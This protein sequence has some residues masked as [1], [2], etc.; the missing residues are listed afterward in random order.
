MQQS[1]RAAVADSGSGNA[2]AHKAKRIFIPLPF[3]MS[4][5]YVYVCV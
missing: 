2:S 5:Y 3:R 1:V 4:L